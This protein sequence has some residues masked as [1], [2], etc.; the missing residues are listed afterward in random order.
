MFHR[1]A[2]GLALLL[3]SGPALA[4]PRANLAVSLTPPSGV[5][6]YETG[7]YAVSVRNLGNRNAAG[8]SLHVAL[9][10][11]HTSPQVHVLGELG[12]RDARCTLEGTSLRCALGTINKGAATLVSFDLALP[13]SSA[14]LVISALATT[15][16]TPESDLS[17]NS[18]RHVA[19]PLTWPTSVSGPAAT[20]NRHCTG[21]GLTSFFECE[22][23]PS[24]ISSHDIVL[25]AGHT[26]TF[27]DPPA[28][29]TGHWWQPSPD[30]LRFQYLDGAAIV[31]EFD[32]RGVGG[33]CFEGP[34]TFPGSS[35]VAIYEVC[36]P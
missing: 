30:R 9:P 5:H 34:T 6:V 29:L 26:I 2:F 28:T 20:H 25:E 18:A 7:R 22:L 21:T 1:F 11:T 17:N 32:G 16:T 10:A 35:W 33:G 12:A 15:T 24:S 3:A 27:V 31:A 13:Y 19:A 23:Y 36:L 8:V 14:P 4:A